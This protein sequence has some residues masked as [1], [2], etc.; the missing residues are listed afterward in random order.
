ME[1]PPNLSSCVFRG[2]AG[3]QTGF[4]DCNRLA[5]C[6]AV[7]M[8]VGFNGCKYISSS[9]VDGNDY[10]ADAGFR[11]CNFISSSE[12]FR[13]SWGFQTCA[14]ISSSAAQDCLSAFPGCSHRD[15]VSAWAY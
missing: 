11:N 14:G 6:K 4:A 15:T 8:G 13:C 1:P 7:R 3:T 9:Q 12:A 10:S 5:A 2:G